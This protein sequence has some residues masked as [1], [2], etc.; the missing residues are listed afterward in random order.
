MEGPQNKLVGRGHVPVLVALQDL[1]V[2]QVQTNFL[3]QHKIN[4]DIEKLHNFLKMPND[5]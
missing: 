3:Y 5:F 2:N 4:S 1:I